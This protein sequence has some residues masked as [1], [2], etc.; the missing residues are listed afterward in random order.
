[1]RSLTP[2]PIITMVIVAL[3]LTSHVAMAG[4]VTTINLTNTGVGGYT[5]A[6]LNSTTVAFY[7]APVVFGVSPS[8]TGYYISNC[9]FTQAPTP[10]ATNIAEPELVRMPNG[11]LALM[12]LRV[13]GK[14]PN[15]TI[16]LQE[17]VWHD[18]HWGSPINVTHSGVVLSYSSD[19]DYIYMLFGSGLESMNGLIEVATMNGAIVKTYHVPGAVSI[20]AYDM[21]GVLLLANGSMAF[22]NLRNGAVTPI[23]QGIVAGVIGNGEYYTYN[24]QSHALTIG[25]A[26]VTI[27]GNYT[28][29]YP[30]QF[31]N[32]YI[33]VT[34]GSVV[35]A[36]KWVGGSLTLLANLTNPGNWGYIEADGVA[37]GDTAVIAFLNTY[38]M[39]LYVSII[40]LNGASCTPGLKGAVTTTTVAPVTATTTTTVT[41]TKTVSNMTVVTSTA[42][43]YVNTT[44]T[45]P[46]NKTVTATVVH[47]L[48]VTVTARAS[49]SSIPLVMVIIIVAIVAV[50]TFLVT[51]R[52]YA[53]L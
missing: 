17:A 20:E 13:Y 50:V 48:T 5:L 46:V 28:G 32:G 24:P 39:R 3:A 31:N 19:G 40:P 37:T 7:Y 12:W 16:V 29:A 6:P 35:S 22:I 25:S 34:W 4:T 47:Y 1:M 21:N 2:I 30:I 26:S 15:V 42:T 44:V 45:M 33:I 38:N 36:L 52:H 51:K 41:A 8:L 27:P 14:Y 11:T 49:G 23:S 43:V 9:Q 18:G 53:W 10:Q